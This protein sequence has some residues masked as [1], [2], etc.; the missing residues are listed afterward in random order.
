[1]LCRAKP[2]PAKW[3]LHQDERGRCTVVIANKHGLP[4]LTTCANPSLG[5]SLPTVA[6]A[7]VTCSKT[8]PLVYINMAGHQS[9]LILQQVTFVQRGG[10]DRRAASQVM[11]HSLV[12]GAQ[13]RREGCSGKHRCAVRRSRLP[14]HRERLLCSYTRRL[15][16]VLCR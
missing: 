5:L 9:Y 13:T 3:L 2:C 11:C 16:A 7:W 15:P 8:T 12:L 10:S 1:M 6:S 4:P 14:D